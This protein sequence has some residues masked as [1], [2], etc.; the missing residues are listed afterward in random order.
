MEFIEFKVEFIDK[1]VEFI[2]KKVEFIEFKVQFIEKKKSLKWETLRYAS[3]VLTLKIDPNAV[4]NPT[5]ALFI[6][7]LVG[8]HHSHIFL[9]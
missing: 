7:K 9:R 6:I 3:V 4:N 5:N 2:E 8:I 1:K